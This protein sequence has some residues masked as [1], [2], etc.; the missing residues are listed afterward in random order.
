MAPIDT[1]ADVRS[2]FPPLCRV[3]VKLGFLQ[4]GGIYVAELLTLEQAPDT[5]SAA[6]AAPAATTE[7]QQQQ[8]EV[9]GLSASNLS[10]SLEAQRR[11]V[12]RLWAEREGPYEASFALA[13]PPGG[14]EVR[15]PS[16]RRSHALPAA[17]AL[18][19]GGMGTVLPLS[20]HTV[21]C[22]LPHRHIPPT[23]PSLPPGGGARHGHRV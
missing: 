15:L 11:V 14:N 1:P 16:C 18:E 3:Q 8:L 9:R 21:C 2:A 20:M 5:A 22:A 12:L 4:T 13:L 7:Q 19:H 6:A 23:H 17:W 10:V